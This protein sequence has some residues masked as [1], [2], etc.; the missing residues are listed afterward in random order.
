M[1]LFY[2]YFFYNEDSKTDIQYRV[3]QI[4]TLVY[5]NYLYKSR[6]CT[7]DLLYCTYKIFFFVFNFKNQGSINSFYFK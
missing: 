4:I 1:K 5:I 7:H 6:K 2:D 3:I